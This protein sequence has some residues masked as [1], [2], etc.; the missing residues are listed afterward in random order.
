M[1]NRRLISYILFVLAVVLF[2]V[3]GLVGDNWLMGLLVGLLAVV[4]GIFFFR[5]AGG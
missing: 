5:R 4:V 1:K 3:L 2:L